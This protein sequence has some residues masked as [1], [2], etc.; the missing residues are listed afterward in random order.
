MTEFDGVFCK[1]IVEQGLRE[2]PNECCGVIAATSDGLLVKVFPATNI[3]ASP[4]SYR[5]DAAEQFRITTE[6]E[7]QGWE[8]WGFYHSHTHTEAYPSTTDR[9]QKCYVFY[10]DTRCLILSLQDR[11]RPVLRSF[12]IRDG[13]V[14]EEEL[15]IT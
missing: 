7:D 5:L 1:E 10:P 13:E 6:I 8:M 9:G 2:F 15:T 11:E 4:S 12:F 14:T 3:E